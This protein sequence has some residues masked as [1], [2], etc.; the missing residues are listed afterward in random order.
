L[1]V[2]LADVVDATAEQRAD[3]VGEVPLLGLLA[4]LG[5]DAE[6]H[7]DTSGGVD[8][9]VDPLV[10]AHA[11]DG[12]EVV[13]ARGVE[14][15][16]VE[17]EA[18]VDDGRDVESGGCAVGLITG[19]GDQRNRSGGAPVD[20]GKGGDEGPVVGGHDPELGVELADEQ[21]GEG[22]V[23]DDV[24]VAERLI[25]CGGVVEL[26]RGG[27]DPGR[28]GLLVDPGPFHFA[29]GVASG[30][31]DDLVTE[32]SQPAGQRVEDELGAPVAGRRDWQPWR[33]DDAN[34]QRSR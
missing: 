33:S 7:A 3:H 14:R 24:A 12:D 11:A 4:H 17:V 32:A 34:R 25:G 16:A 5:R 10:G 31:Q 23:V 8:G 13:P 2:D 21:P 29:R 27:A 28:D 15:V 6:R 19:D 1:V 30:E 18:V 9:V 22:G 26:D 20:V